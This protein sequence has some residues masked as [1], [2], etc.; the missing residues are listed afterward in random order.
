MTVP[1][2]RRPGR[3]PAGPRAQ[4]D[5]T[6]GWL[7]VARGERRVPFSR[8]RVWRALAVLRPYCAVCD[9]SYVVDGASTKRGTEF[10]CVPGRLDGQRPPGGA[11]RGRVVEWEPEHR[12]A[13]RLE[14]T[15]EV[16]V[17][18]V[19]LADAPD[20]ST[21]VAVTLTHEPLTGGLFQRRRQRK[22]IRTVAQET[23]ESELAKVAD[24]VHQAEQVTG[25]AEDPPG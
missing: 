7:T 22:G 19:E 9:V 13:T 6:P 17:T 18:T 1:D 3:G 12:V 8:A 23:V 10:V 5:G 16:W 15:P 14:L 20:G 25:D 2:S 4:T 21:D 11:P 24:H